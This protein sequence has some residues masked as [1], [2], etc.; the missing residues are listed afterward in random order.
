[1]TGIRVNE[2][3]ILLDEFKKD[4]NADQITF[5]PLKKNKVRKIGI[6][7]SIRDVLKTILENNCPKTSAIVKYFQRLAKR[8][9]I[10]FSVHDMRCTYTSE[11]ISNIS[12]LD[13]TAKMS[14]SDISILAQENMG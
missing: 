5:Q 3:N 11:F 7:S 9:K 1:M 14:K 10:P 12:H 13:E 8:L 6:D 2:I 4:I